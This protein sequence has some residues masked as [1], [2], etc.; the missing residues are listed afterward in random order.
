MR[1]GSLQMVSEPVTGRC[2]GLLAVP[3]R[4]VDMRR[5]ASKDA[6]PQRGVDCDVPHWLGRRTNQGRWAPKGG[7]LWCPTLVGE[8]NKPPFIRV[9]KPSPSRRR[10]S[11]KREAQRGQYLLAVDLGHSRRRGSPK[12]EAQRGQYLLAVDLG[13]YKSL[14][15]RAWLWYYVR[16]HDSPQ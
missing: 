9:W 13:H 14:K 12:R 6:G 4:R 15:F 16:N 11:P 10:G 2:A 1:V 3:W 7:G 8:K 5:C